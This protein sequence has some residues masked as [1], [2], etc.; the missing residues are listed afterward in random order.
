MIGVFSPKI[1]FYNKTTK[2]ITKRNLPLWGRLN[3]LLRETD[4]T[5]KRKCKRYNKRGKPIV[6]TKSRN[7]GVPLPEILSYASTNAPR[8]TV[9]PRET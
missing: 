2:L 6:Y 1:V 3:F 9:S 8:T 5:Y 4:K 7:S